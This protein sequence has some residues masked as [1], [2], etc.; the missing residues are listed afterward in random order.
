M[1]KNKREILDVKIKIHNKMRLT[2]DESFFIIRSTVLN[3]EYSSYIR[4]KEVVR[5]LPE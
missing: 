3:K 4:I 5:D 1:H 2:R